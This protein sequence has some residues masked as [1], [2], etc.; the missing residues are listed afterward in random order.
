MTKI[1]ESL[2]PYAPILNVSGDL[3]NSAYFSQKE[4]G[5]M[6]K[7][8]LQPLY[9]QE[10]YYWGKEPNELAKKILN[11]AAPP[12]KVVDIGAGEGR[13]SV[14]L[15]QQGFDVLAM[16]IAPAG[17][18]KVSRL[19]EE[20]DTQV[21]TFEANINDVVFSDS[22]DVV[23]SIGALQY[24]EPGN[25]SRQF[26]HFK[27]ITHPNGIHVLFAF[28]DHSEV[29]IAPDWGQ[30]E[31]L[32]QPK[33]LESYYSDWQKL[34]QEQIIFDCNS[35]NIPHQHAADILIVQKT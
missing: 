30:N 2:P 20:F 22:F 21:Q 16:D 29:A 14:F 31:Y 33:E 28:M 3:L 15:A 32:Y 13:D 8:Q 10:N 9:L 4:C 34:E 12:R 1:G 27:S 24:I 5:S 19:A 17:L 23:Y 25:R 11:Y 6:D 18:D 35:S 26:D 7:E